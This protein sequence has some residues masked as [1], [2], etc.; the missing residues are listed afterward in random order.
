MSRPRAVHHD[1]VDDLGDFTATRR[2][3]GVAALAFGIGLVG[4]L[5]AK[6]LLALISLATNIFFFGRLSTAP[7]S[8]ADAHLGWFVIAIPMIGGL[9]IGLMARYGS[10]RIR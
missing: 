7:V 10:E 2:V 3:I 5:L 8:P 1:A 9:I 4:A 6:A